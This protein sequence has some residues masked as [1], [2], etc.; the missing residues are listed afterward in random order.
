MSEETKSI[1]KKRL[2]GKWLGSLLLA[3]ASGAIIIVIG[4]M[5]GVLPV[6]ALL[7][8]ACVVVVLVLWPLIIFVR[9]LFSRGWRQVLFRL[10]CIATLI[11][12]FY[13]EENWRGK[14]AWN[15]YVRECEARGESMDWNA[16]IPPQ[17][18]DGQNLAMCPLLKPILDYA[19]T[20]NLPN[21][22]HTI[23]N[24]TNGTMRIYRLSARWNDGWLADKKYEANHRAQQALDENPVTN[25]WV[26]LVAWQNY[27]RTGT[28]LDGIATNKTPA[29]DVLLALRFMEPD[30]AELQGEAA[31]R[32]L[33][34]WP[35]QYEAAFK[36][37]IL[38]PHLADIRCINRTLQ[39]RSSARLADGDVAGGMADIQLGLRLANSVADEP[40]L[41]TLLVRAFA[42]EDIFQPLRE[43]IARHQFSEA[44]LALVQQQL[45]SL[46]F[47]KAYQRAFQ[48]ERTMHSQWDKLSG[49]T[50]DD[51]F[52]GMSSH[53]DDLFRVKLLLRFAPRGWIYQNQLALCRLEDQLMFR[54][55]DTRSHLVLPTLAKNPDKLADETPGV[56]TILTKWI[57]SFKTL[58]QAP[59][60]TSQHQTTID[61]TVIA[62]ASERY[63]L[64]HG[65]FPESLDALAPSFIAQL[66]H[67]VIGGGPLKYRRTADGQFVL[68]SIG[69]NEKDDGGVTVI[70][71]G[72][73]QPRFEEGDWVWRYPKNQ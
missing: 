69:W 17:I 2:G 63:R 23:W 28:N 40:F 59:L 24:D 67:D 3:L 6:G 55:I 11:A 61:Q 22:N 21:G 19:Q 13:A 41:I 54:G 71:K 32:P 45:S 65:E 57:F 58:E 36:S 48:T 62:C 51:L 56:F 66:P 53:G 1:W 47:F 14:R 43:G 70:P 20:N 46:D 7:A 52:R 8:V 10:A 15:N 42:F 25:G 9:W 18:P 5:A 29:Q 64:A 38:L 16:Y 72:S 49:S 27:F 37:G 33:T 73:S 4:A 60:G 31:K 34:R 44:Q 68:Y 39:L 26:N 30:L 12:V 50:V 35:V